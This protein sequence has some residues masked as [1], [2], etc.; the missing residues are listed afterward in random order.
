MNL[1]SPPDIMKEKE[2]PVGPCICS[3]WDLRDPNKS[4]TSGF[5]VED[6]AIP[7]AFAEV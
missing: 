3:V 7:G 1:F 4:V 5:I 6:M 2:G